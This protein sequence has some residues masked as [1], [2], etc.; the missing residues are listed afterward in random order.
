LEETESSR[1]GIRASTSL[2]DYD[3]QLFMEGKH[4]RLYEK[5]GSHL[6]FLDGVEGASFAVWAPNAR[7]VSVIG[8]F[9]GWNPTQHLLAK[10]AD[11]SGVWEGFVPGLSAGA[12]YKYHIVSNFNDYAADK[13]DPFARLWE[14]PPR[15][16]SV[17]WGTDH[18]W[19]DS[20]WMAERGKR[21]SLSAPM[22]I[23]EA[24][25]GSWKRSEA[26]DSWLGY[27]ETAQQL[28]AYASEMG[29]THVEFLP[30]ME[31]PFYGS[32]GYQT[33]GYFAPTSRYGTP[34]DMKYLV[35]HLHKNGIGVFLDWV[36]SHF[37][38]D[39]HGLSFFDGT[40][41]FEYADPRRGFHP[42]W[43]TCIF[44]YGRNE[45]R[46]FILSAANFWLDVYH[47]DGLRCDAVSSMLYLDYSR[48]PGEWVANI[49]GGRENLEAISL[50]KFLNESVY[51][52]HPDVQM[53]AEE[54]TAWPMVS[55]P[56]YTGGLGFGM[57]WD[58]GWMHDTLHYY[59]TDPLF[60]KYHHDEL[61]FS[62]WYFFSEN[63]ILPL[64]HDEVVHGKGSLLAKFPG[65]SWQKHAN[66]RLLLGYMYGHPGK[67]LLFMGDELA[68]RDEWHHDG[69]LNWQLLEDPAS[70]GVQSWVKDLNRFLRAE[71]ALHERDFALEGFEW[72]DYRDSDNSVVSFI[73]RSESGDSILVVCNNT[74]VPR[75]EYTLGVPV[76]GRWQESLNSDAKEYGGSGVGNLGRV[77]ATEKQSNGRPYTLTISL[78]P[79]GCLFLKPENQGTA[80]SK[81]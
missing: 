15:T 79:L 80:A 42:D 78:P 14:L 10:R 61:T 46:S 31:H 24:H 77:E 36:P 37:P 16:A 47:A 72:V 6:H 76:G 11:W 7:S 65:D 48:K 3:V 44:D 30:V 28:A 73:R 2:T 13:G 57:K 39:K 69:S 63:F 38:S 60:R 64:S 27:R 5:L 51:A 55:R 1:A 50:L 68:E 54:S 9:N 49:H 66:L 22:A 71:P 33:S 34:E 58:L 41:L 53:M 70:A 81:A 67:K 52:G 43:K 75:N 35:D 23:Y 25:L 45:V 17:V 32:W 8:D 18:Q 20:V 59:G 26:D 74:P 62:M 56:T 29:F 12:V 4:T 19:G 21:N 40:H